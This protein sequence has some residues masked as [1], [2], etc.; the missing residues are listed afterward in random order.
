MTRRCV[1]CDSIGIDDDDLTDAP[2]GE[3]AKESQTVQFH[4]GAERRLCPQDEGQGQTG[5]DVETCGQ[6]GAR[7]FRRG[8]EGEASQGE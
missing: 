4:Q 1:W 3:V 2:A 6:A 7:A 8:E 5:V